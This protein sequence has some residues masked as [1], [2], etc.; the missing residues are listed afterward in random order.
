[1]KAA[2]VIVLLL[3]SAWLRADTLTTTNGETF[4]GSIVAETDGAYQ[5]RM[6][7]HDFSITFIRD[8]PTNE[9]KSVVRDTPEQ[10]AARA[11]YE[12]ICRYRL[13]PDNAQPAKQCEAAIAGMKNFLA[14]YPDA[15]P[16]WRKTVEATLPVWEDELANV[17]KGLVKLQ[18]RWMS[19]ADRDVA[20]QKMRFQTIQTAAENLRKQIA[21]ETAYQTQVANALTIAERNLAAAE[22]FLANLKDYTEPT[23]EY[24]PVGGYPQAIATPRGYFVWQPPFWEKVVSGEKV[25]VNGQRG[26]AEKRVRDYQT[27]VNDYRTT[28][29]S[30]N[31]RLVDLRAKLAQT[32]ASLAK[33]K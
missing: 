2:S 20:I 11:A 9:V 3:W 26:T 27:S 6:A 29:E 16:E 24:R 19:P 31:R 4:T 1:V 8:F 21:K 17:S 7:N 10:K 18:R 5:L 28:L 15:P 23:Y 30:V 25:V 33:G 13:Y 22:Q 32:E 12:T 14:T